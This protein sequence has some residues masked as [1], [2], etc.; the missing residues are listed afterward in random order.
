MATMNESKFLYGSLTQVL[1]G[2]T[3]KN[4]FAPV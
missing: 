4:I 1:L 2:K 3:D